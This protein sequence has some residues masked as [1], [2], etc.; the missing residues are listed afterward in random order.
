MENY[1]NDSIS[2]DNDGLI[3]KSHHKNIFI[4]FSKIKKAYLKKEPHYKR[5]Y[6][7][8]SMSLIL[9]LISIFF[10]FNQILFYTILIFASLFY[11]AGIIYNYINYKVIIHLTDDT[12]KFNIPSAYKNDAKKIISLI[13][14]NE[15]K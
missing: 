3:L 1:I 4:P 13:K 2:I 9:V 6:L 5:N 11:I 10:N 15:K 8:L 12:I 7:L 14:K